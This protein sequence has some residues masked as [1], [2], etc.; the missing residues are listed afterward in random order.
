M[1]DSIKYVTQDG[2][3]M[4]ARTAVWNTFFDMYR[5]IALE[6]VQPSSKGQKVVRWVGNFIGLGG[7]IDAAHILGFIVSPAGITSIMFIL[8]TLLVALFSYILDAGADILLMILRLVGPIALCFGLIRSTQHIAW[9]WLQRFIEVCL[10]KLVYA[11]FI[12][13][14]ATIFERLGQVAFDPS[15]YQD[16]DTLTGL[17]CSFTA[18]LLS[19]V[20]GIVALFMLASIPSICASLVEG[21][22]A[23]MGT[24]VSLLLGAAAYGAMSVARRAAASAGTRLRGGGNNGSGGVKDAVDKQKQADRLG[25]KVDSERQNYHQMQQKAAAG[26]ASPQAMQKAGEKLGTLIGQHNTAQ[27]HAIAA[28]ARI[29]TPMLK[30]AAD[31]IKSAERMKQDLATLSA[32][33]QKLPDSPL[34]DQA[35]AALKS[36]QEAADKAKAFA[37]Q[38]TKHAA[39]TGTAIQGHLEKEAKKSL[40]QAA[41]AAAASNAMLKAARDEGGKLAGLANE[42]GI[43]FSAGGQNPNN[44]IQNAIDKQN[45]AASKQRE[46]IAAKQELQRV[47]DL[48]RQGNASPTDVKNT[49]EKYGDAL[50]EARAARRDAV[51]AISSVTKPVSAEAKEDLKAASQIEKDAVKLQ[52]AFAKTPDSAVK[53][54]AQKALANTQRATETARIQANEARRKTAAAASA[55]KGGDAQ[56]AQEYMKA[57]RESLTASRESLKEAAIHAQKADAIARSLGI[58]PDSDG[59]GGGTGGPKGSGPNGSGGSGSGSG[60]K[61][62]GSGGSGGPNGKGGSSMRSSGSGGGMTNSGGSQSSNFKTGGPSAGPTTQA[63]FG[64]STNVVGGSVIPK[65]STADGSNGSKI[66]GV[67]V[68]LQSG[69]VS[70]VRT[71]DS[72]LPAPTKSSGNGNSPASA[73]YFQ[74]KHESDVG[75]TKNASSSPNPISSSGNS[76]GS[77]SPASISA[78]S[79]SYV[80]DN[81]KGNPGTSGSTENKNLSSRG[82]RTNESSTGDR[83]NKTTAPGTQSSSANPTT[84]VVSPKSEKSTEVSQMQNKAQSDSFSWNHTPVSSKSQKVSDPP[85]KEYRESGA[86][87]I[88]SGASEKTGP[89]KAGKTEKEL[90]ADHTRSVS[91]GRFDKNNQTMGP[92]DPPTSHHGSINDRKTIGSSFVPTSGKLE[93][94]R[95]A[96][97]DSTVPRDSVGKSTRTI[98]S[99]KEQADSHEI[100]N[101]NNTYLASTHEGSPVRESTKNLVGSSGVVET[102]GSNQKNNNPS[103]KGDQSRTGIQSLPSPNSEADGWSSRSYNLDSHSSS[104]KYEGKSAS[105]DRERDQNRSGNHEPRRSVTQSLNNEAAEHWVR[106]ASQKQVEALDR[107]LNRIQAS[108]ATNYPE[109]RIDYKANNGKEPLS[110]SSGLRAAAEKRFSEKF[111]GIVKEWRYEKDN[112]QL[113]GHGFRKVDPRELNLNHPPETYYVNGLKAIKPEP[114][115]RIVENQESPHKKDQ[116][117]SGNDEI[118]FKPSNQMST[119]TFDARKHSSDWVEWARK[120]KPDLVRDNWQILIPSE[121]SRVLRVDTPEDVAR[122]LAHPKYSMEA[123]GGSGRVP[124]L[125]AIAR[126]FDGFSVG[127]E[128]ATQTA[129]NFSAYPAESTVWFNAAFDEQYSIKP[130]NIKVPANKDL[131]RQNETEESPK[132]SDSPFK[133]DDLER[134]RGLR[135]SVEK[136]INKLLSKKDKQHE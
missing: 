35:L 59:P 104:T 127:H 134:D 111:G 47:Q 91:S 52:S 51:A 1:A 93:S 86:T 72:T 55:I 85:A 54:E 32:A 18:M 16:L 109:V 99:G 58:K 46:E 79:R 60:P 136:V 45:I 10:W 3:Q 103:F 21:R 122:L 9:G 44:L 132:Q 28:A 102:K 17:Q 6:S 29:T 34:K 5:N 23:G 20:V 106:S 118:H 77:K 7:V 38:A 13:G 69:A 62:S 81:S 125:K 130:H 2:Q 75:L 120:E 14:I 61:N 53:Q 39:A 19:I 107:S 71:S 84:G 15:Y 98:S 74:K 67:P 95:D 97:S 119:S 11:I 31:N 83:K 121:S 42:L 37:E 117:R 40:D 123:P 131:S 89:S 66:A 76:T 26:L 63:K 135:R 92:K 56:K 48:A 80:P 49:S 27:A 57:A 90:P 110:E 88:K 70:K 30:Q 96:S 68:P 108:P 101:K 8:T 115:L 24:T 73:G 129:N 112:G 33:V 36:M 105:G 64:N 124:N 82:S 116:S 65:T 4:D 133:Q 22:S 78:N 113:V 50:A 128:V 87:P 94:K 126:D 43:K 25:R 41:A 114:Q 12:V 100:V